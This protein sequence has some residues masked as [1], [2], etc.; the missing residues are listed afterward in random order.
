[1]TIWKR[2]FAALAI[3]AIAAVSFAGVAGAASNNA[4]RDERAR[5]TESRIYAESEGSY[6]D[7]DMTPFDY[8][9]NNPGKYKN[10]RQ[11]PGDYYYG[12]FH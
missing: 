10:I 3:G 1:M 5:A 11:G 8:F 9:F 6:R 2:G 4:Q 7:G 12:A